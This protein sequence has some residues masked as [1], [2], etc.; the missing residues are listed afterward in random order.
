[1]T[2]DTK[3]L[4]RLQGAIAFLIIMSLVGGGAV[5]T[6]EQMKKSNDRA[7]L[8]AT[9]KRKEVQTKL[10]QARDEQQELTEK[11]NR[12][13]ALRDRGY[14]G[15]ERRLDWV[16]AIARI[17]AARRIFKLE[18]EFAPQRRVD[19]SILPGGGSAGGFEIM[20]SQM[21]LEIHLLHERE[22]LDFLADLRADLRSTVQALVHVRSCAIE[23]LTPSAADRGS[24]AQL[25]A[26]CTLEWVTLRESK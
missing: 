8:E 3:D 15:P 1:M 26:E 7:L 2:L 25:K 20:S 5:W 11:L 23:R 21:R 19:T 6:T 9:A 17:K 4:K 14:I 22:L 13:Q 24:K 12:F 10:G 18:Y 16:E